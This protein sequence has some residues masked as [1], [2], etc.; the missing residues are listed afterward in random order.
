[1]SWRYGRYNILYSLKFLRDKYFVVLPNSAQNKNFTE[2]IFI[3]KLPAMPCICYERKLLQEK[4]SRPCSGLWNLSTSKILGHTVTFQ[5]WSLRYRCR[6]KWSG[7]LVQLGH[8]QHKLSNNSSKYRRIAFKQKV[9]MFST[10]ILYAYHLIT[11][12]MAN[13]V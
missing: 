13:I 6:Y 1:M 4:F 2:K 9:P 11:C 12:I 10:H 7:A 5:E 8:Y 3:V